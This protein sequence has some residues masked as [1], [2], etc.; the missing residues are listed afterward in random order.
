MEQGKELSS[1]GPML[2]ERALLSMAMSVI[3]NHGVPG[4]PHSSVLK[5]HG[6]GGDCLLLL[7]LPRPHDVGT[8]LPHR[9]TN[10]AQVLAGRAHATPA[11]VSLTMGCACFGG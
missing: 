2:V 5:P 10:P 3:L 8:H 1:L 4:H 6:E 7:Y 11:Q 9:H